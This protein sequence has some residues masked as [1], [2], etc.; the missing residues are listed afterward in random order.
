MWNLQ[1]N[2]WSDLQ[3]RVNSLHISGS[4]PHGSALQVFRVEVRQMRSLNKFRR[5]FYLISAVDLRSTKYTLSSSSNHVL[6]FISLSR[7]SGSRASSS[8]FLIEISG[9]IQTM[10]PAVNVCLF[11]FL[12][13]KSGQHQHRAPT[14]SRY[15]TP[16]VIQSLRTSH[17]SRPYLPASVLGCTNAPVAELREKS[18]QFKICWKV[19]AQEWR[20]SQ[21]QINAWGFSAGLLSP[22]CWE[23]GQNLKLP[24]PTASNS[25]PDI[26]TWML[27]TSQWTL[28]SYNEASCC[29]SFR[30]DS[31]P[32]A[33]C[34]S[35]LSAIY[36]MRG[37]LQDS[38]TL[39]STGEHS[40]QPPLQDPMILINI[41]FFIKGRSHP[42]K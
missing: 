22:R 11:L 23:N 39:L 6:L 8:C 3:G 32:S 30:D 13:T 12:C 24:V 28:K 42:F 26:H 41:N 31:R 5:W 27:S 25:S 10:W 17:R 4:M 21:Q 2:I 14:W 34:S 1:S 33:E 16:T 18:L 29:G 35:H 36:R 40:S 38:D 19:F 15:R 9:N 37:E 7:N 20:R